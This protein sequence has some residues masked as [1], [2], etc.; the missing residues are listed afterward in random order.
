MHAVLDKSWKQHVTKQWMYGHLPSILQTKH[1]LLGTARESKDVLMDSYTWTHQC[2]PTSKNLHLSAVCWL[3]E[4]PSVADR[5]RGENQRNPFCW[6]TLIIIHFFFFFFFLHIDYIMNVICS[7]IDFLHFCPFIF[8][9]MLVN[10]SFFYTGNFTAVHQST[11]LFFKVFFTDLNL[12]EKS[13]IQL[14]KYCF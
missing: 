5:D 2:W 10:F 11:K 6:C 14:V 4:L 9:F 3:E 8:N 7:I 13:S 1:V 12:L